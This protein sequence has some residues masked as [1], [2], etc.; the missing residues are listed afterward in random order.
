MNILSMLGWCFY[1]VWCMDCFG[2]KACPCE[3][4]CNALFAAYGTE[5]DID[6]IIEE[7]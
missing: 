1:Q 2:R 7:I 3:S 4:V 6:A 5:D